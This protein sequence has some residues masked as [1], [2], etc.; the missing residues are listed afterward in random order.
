[1]YKGLRNN[2]R[3]VANQHVDEIPV[4]KVLEGGQEKLAALLG[5][6][7]KSKDKDLFELPPL[8]EES[9]LDSADSDS[10][11]EDILAAINVDHS[12]DLH[13]VGLIM[14]RMSGNSGSRDARFLEM[15]EPRLLQVD[16]EGEKFQ[17]LPVHR[18]V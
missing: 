4:L 12:T 2:Y 15:R 11:R 17:S 16:I 5:Q 1:L 10:D 13:Q 3:V 14:C 6:R 8:P 9:A 18:L 7:N